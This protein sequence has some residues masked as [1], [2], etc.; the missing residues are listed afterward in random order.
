MYIRTPLQA[1]YHSISTYFFRI[2]TKLFLFGFCVFAYL[3]EAIEYV[4]SA[5]L[6][7]DAN[8]IWDGEHYTAKMLTFLKHS[9]VVG[10]NNAIT[11]KKVFKFN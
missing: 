1:R 7:N 9:V 4:G 6:I 3:R 11:F 10:G 2:I 5:L 8:A